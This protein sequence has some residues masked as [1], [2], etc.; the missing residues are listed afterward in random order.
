MPR[1]YPAATTF[2]DLKIA[3]AGGYTDFSS[4]D[5]FKLF[6]NT[7]SDQIDVVSFGSSPTITAGPRLSVP[8]GQICAVSLKDGR[9][10]F[11][12]GRGG[13]S[14]RAV[15]DMTVIS[16]SS[17]VVNAVS[18]E[19][20][21]NPRYFHTCTTLADGSVL[22]TGGMAEDGSGLPKTMDSI[23]IFMPRPT[24]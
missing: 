20:L 1:S 19:K 22:V 11:I 18:G 24:E 17:K 21:A 9:A 13:G 10:L 23:E 4:T 5:P 2:G 16:E 6:P 12:G 8:R 15:G 3:V 7:P 14:L